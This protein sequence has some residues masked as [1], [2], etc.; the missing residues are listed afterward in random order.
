[1]GGIVGSQVGDGRRTGLGL[2]ETVDRHDPLQQLR[3][4]A[5]GQLERSLDRR[6][7]GSRADCVHAYALLA[8]LDGEAQSHGDDAALARIVGGGPGLALVGGR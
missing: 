4:G 8:V 5:L 7:E 6:V 2:R 3:V 1:M